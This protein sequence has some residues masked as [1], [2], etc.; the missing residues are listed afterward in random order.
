MKLFIALAS[1][2]LAGT[3]TS[4]YGQ[5]FQETK[6]L[7]RRGD[8]MVPVQD[9]YFRILNGDTINKIDEEGLLQGEWERLYP[10]GSFRCKG[11]YKNGKKDG[12]WERKYENGN[13]QY[14]VNV[15]DG[16]SHGLSKFYYKNG[17]LK[18][19]ANYKN[20]FPDGLIKTYNQNGS[21]LSEENYTNVEDNGI[22][23]A[24][25]GIYLLDVDT[26]LNLVMT[27]MNIKG[28]AI[29]KLVEN[30]A[31]YRS[32]LKKEDIIIKINQDSVQ[33]SKDLIQLTYTFNVKDTL[34][35]KLIRSGQERDIQLK[36]TEKDF[37]T[38]K[39]LLHGISKYY[40]E[41][42]NLLR[43][44]AYNKGK[45]D[46]EWKFYSVE[47][48]LTATVKYDNGEAIETKGFD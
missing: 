12:Y 35:V 40:D 45:R 10:N 46:G 6:H 20:G 48:K 29:T 42:G 26:T 1:I 28:V 14:Q 13:W 17:Y 22:K 44:G 24:K 47:G 43:E 4:S 23:K 8:T 30:S 18:K 27:P 34:K 38:V 31:A 3:I 41:N 36:L 32:G 39:A 5:S 7:S 25:I 37:E 16:Y 2:M 19:V 11:R 15:K 33:S 21:I 9:Q